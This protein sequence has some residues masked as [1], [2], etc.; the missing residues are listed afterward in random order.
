MQCNVIALHYNA[1]TFL[2]IDSITR[3]FTLDSPFP[4]GVNI[5]GAEVKDLA[6]ETETHGVSV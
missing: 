5:G 3:D 2:D 4:L 6:H 1:C